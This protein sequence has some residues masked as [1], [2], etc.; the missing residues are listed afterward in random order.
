[1]L[2]PYREKSQELNAF[3]QN[4]AIQMQVSTDNRL[5][6]TIQHL[7][8]N[9]VDTGRHSPLNMKEKSPKFTNVSNQNRLLQM[10]QDSLEEEMKWSLDPISEHDFKQGVID[11]VEA[12]NIVKKSDSQL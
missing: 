11:Q 8:S 2:S 4:V 10:S 7:T 1:M 12:D 5:E 3:Q 9:L 6:D